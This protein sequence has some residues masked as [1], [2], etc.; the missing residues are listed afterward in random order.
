MCN[1]VFQ[2]ALLGTTLIFPDL[3]WQML[4]NIPAPVL[5][6]LLNDLFLSINICLYC[7]T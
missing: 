6:G 2:C 5:K 4:E 1:F 7:D 3:S